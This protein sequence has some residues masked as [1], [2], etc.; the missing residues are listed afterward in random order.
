MEAAFYRLFPGEDDTGIVLR[1]GV[2]G[3]HIDRQ[4]VNDSVFVRVALLVVVDVVDLAFQLFC[5]LE[6]LVR[7]HGE[8]L[9]FLPWAASEC[10]VT[11]VFICAPWA[12]HKYASSEI[13]IGLL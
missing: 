4:P 2:D 8:F 3:P 7:R 10:N 5:L 11:R 13:P 12:C 6:V 1:C 9:F